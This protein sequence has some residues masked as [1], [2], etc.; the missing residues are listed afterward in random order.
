[1]IQNLTEKQLPAGIVS[2]QSIVESDER[3]PDSIV[4]SLVEEGSISLLVG[5]AKEGKSMLAEQ[6]SIDVAN[7]EPFLGKLATEPG[8][9]LYVD[10]EN[11]RHRIKSRGEDLGAGRDLSNVLFASYDHISEKTLGLDGEDLTRLRG[12]V[13]EIQPAL[14]IIDP[15]RLAT[16][17]SMA[18]KDTEVVKV[19]STI[20]GLL[21]VSPRTGILL[22][23]HLKK[24]QRA[25][26]VKLFDDPRTWVER[27]FGSQALLAHVET[28]IGLERDDDTM[29][30]LATVPRSY[31]PIVWTLEKVAQSERF[32]LA[33][34]SSQISRW[35]PA[36][37]EAWTKLPDEFSWTEGTRAV[38]NSRLDRLIRRA[39]PL[40]LIVQDPITRRYRKGVKGWEKGNLIENK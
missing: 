10:Y 35:S 31:E 5:R 23:H 11:R 40:G 1:M 36:L 3:A 20:S 6:L 32:I 21:D 29:Y 13:E 26:Q 30:T 16:S 38:G 24:G 25:E 17:G 15:L 14:L 37:Q 7:G 39:E 27:T 22:V 18:E 4:E 33:Q 19:V 34:A 9:V 28:I 12:V 2:W 8:Q